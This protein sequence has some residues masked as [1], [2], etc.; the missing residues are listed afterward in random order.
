[1]TNTNLLHRSK[2]RL[3]SLIISLLDFL[4]FING[5]KHSPIISSS[6]NSS[7]LIS[8]T[9]GGIPLPSLP[10]FLLIILFITS[11]V[12]SSLKFQNSF[13]KLINPSS[14]SASMIT[15][16]SGYIGLS[17]PSYYKLW[18]TRNWLWLK[19]SQSVA[20]SLFTLLSS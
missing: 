7:S 2:R 10:T 17:P 13:L 20:Y 6:V 14:Y 11:V 3:V 4:V 1:M 5:M 19:L 18:R 12:I 8:T 15:S 16:V 9:H